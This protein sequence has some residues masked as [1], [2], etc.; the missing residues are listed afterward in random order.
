M[1]NDF[2]ADI[3]AIGRIDAV[4]MI[5]DVVCRSTGMGFAA[6][7]RVTDDR[8]IACEVLDAIGFGLKPGGEL[9]VKTTI[10]DEIRDSREAVVIDEVAKDPV[11]SNPSHAG[12]LW[13]SKLYFHA[14]YPPGRLVVRYAMRH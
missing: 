3:D 5:L 4:P 9:A 1:N 10:C 12:D 13:F 11:Y 8:W 2:Q 7:A 6:V 14:Y